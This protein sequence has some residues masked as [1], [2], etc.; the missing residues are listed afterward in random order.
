MITKN[1]EIKRVKREDGKVSFVASTSTEDRYGDVINQSGWQ[2]KAYKRNPV[3]LFNHNPTELPIGRGIVEI[4]NGDLHIDVEFDQE[5]PRAKAIERKAKA[6]FLNAVSV[7]FMPVDSKMRKDLEKSHPAY[8]EKSRGM[9]F[10]KSELLEV[11]IVTIPANS[12]ATLS[13]AKNM[14]SFSSLTIRDLIREEI[15][16]I[17]DVEIMEDGNYKIIIAGEKEEDPEEPEEQEEELD[18][19]EEEEIV[20]EEE[21]ETEKSNSTKDLN[22]IIQFILSTRNL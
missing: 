18:L 10:G 13:S 3:V 4:K 22:E 14:S 16:H 11:S 8:S 19:Q 17:L 21:K 7:G 12:E 9:Y 5:D 2:L 20:E 15:K 1:I 6:G